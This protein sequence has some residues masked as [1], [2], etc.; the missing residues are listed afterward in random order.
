MN[1]PPCPQRPKRGRKKGGKNE[2]LALRSGGQGGRY[3][4]EI[5]NDWLLDL[6][7]CVPIDDATDSDDESYSSSSSEDLDDEVLNT[8]EEAECLTDMK[9]THILP[10]EKLAKVVKLHM[11]CKKCSIWAQEDHFRFP[12]V[13]R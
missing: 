3:F 9:G 5:D 6:K 13:C 2:L 10:I 4:E 7:A 1:D 11:C 8:F 12:F